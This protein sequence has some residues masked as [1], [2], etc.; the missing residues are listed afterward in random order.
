MAKKRQGDP[1]MPAPDFGRSLEGLS[2]NL[3]VSDV[4]AAVDFADR[5]FVKRLEVG[6]DGDGSV[7]A[8][9]SRRSSIRI[10][11]ADSDHLGVR[12]EMSVRPQ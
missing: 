7:V 2:I 10:V 6:G 5:D 3:L 11:V 1:W 4:A 12:A 8:D 9:L